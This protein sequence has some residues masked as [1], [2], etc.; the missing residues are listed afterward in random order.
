MSYLFMK[1]LCWH[2]YSCCFWCLHFCFYFFC[3]STLYIIFTSFNNF[4]FRYIHFWLLLLV[5]FSYNTSYVYILHQYK[6]SH[7]KQSQRRYH[8]ICR[9]QNRRRNVY[10]RI[11]IILYK[12]MVFLSWFWCHLRSILKNRR[13]L[14]W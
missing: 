13:N 9:H 11:N 14:F 8:R 10:V 5:S 3:F 6:Y 7:H 1:L 2:F 4:L 12:I